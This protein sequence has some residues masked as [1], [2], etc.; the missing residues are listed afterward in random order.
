MVAPAYSAARRTIS[1]AAG[2]GKK[3]V[4]APKSKK[5]SKKKTLAVTATVAE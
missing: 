3:K 2:F 1:K 4:V 5:S